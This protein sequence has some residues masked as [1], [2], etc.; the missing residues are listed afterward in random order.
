[1][2][3][4]TCT[5]ILYNTG[6]VVRQKK[7]QI[8][9]TALNGTCQGILSVCHRFASPGMGSLFYLPKTGWQLLVHLSITFM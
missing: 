5:H 8:A 4:D 3:Y 2:Q 9:E 1:M 7:L 6:A